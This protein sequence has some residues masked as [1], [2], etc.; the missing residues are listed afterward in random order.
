[1]TQAARSLSLCGEQSV[2]RACSYECK[3]KGA[4]PSVPGSKPDSTFLVV[5][6]TS[7]YGRLTTLSFVCL[8]ACDPVLVFAVCNSAFR[9]AMVK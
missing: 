5:F 3:V 2:S 1:M 9:G 7:A 4:S 6:C 8:R